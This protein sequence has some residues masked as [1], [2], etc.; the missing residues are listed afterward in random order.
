[1]GRAEPKPSALLAR[2]MLGSLEL[3]SVQH[4]AQTEA[5]PAARSSKAQQQGQ[6]TTLRYQWMEL[7]RSLIE[8]AAVFS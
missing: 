5:V 1:M 3:A 2:V 7:N 6:P 8:R 4:A